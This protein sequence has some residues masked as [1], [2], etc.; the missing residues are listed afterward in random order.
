MPHWEVQSAIRGYYKHEAR[1]ILSLT[2]GISI[3]AGM[4]NDEGKYRELVDSL[5]IKAGYK[6][7]EVTNNWAKE[8]ISW[9]TSI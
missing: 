7:K 1:R 8:L 4:F 6:E 2:D 9:A 5:M 3:G